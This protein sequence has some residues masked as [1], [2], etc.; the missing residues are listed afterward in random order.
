VTHLKARKRVAKGT[1]SP[2][3]NLAQV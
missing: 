3:I 1:L 2:F